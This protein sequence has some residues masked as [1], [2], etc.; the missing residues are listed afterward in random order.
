[1]RHSGFV[2]TV[3]ALGGH[4]HVGWVFDDPD[5]YH[6]VVERFLADGRAAGQQVM[7]VADGDPTAAADPAAQVR[8]YA[9]ATERALADGYTGLRVAADATPL[10]RTAQERAAFAR[11]EFLMDVFMARRPMS[12]L[13]G[14]NRSELGDEA[15]AEL[16][17]MHPVA[18]R[19]STPLRLFAT[20]RP[21]VAAVLA[22]EVDP[23][24]HAQ[25]QNALGRAE[26]PADGGVVTLDAR[27]LTFID[28]RALIRLVEH[29]R[30]RGAGTALLVDPGSPVA[31]LAGLLQLGDLR[32]VMS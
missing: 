5:E 24:G 32:V 3:D 27:E 6:P 22:G 18:R 4:D 23:G 16:A 2:D 25:L 29:V 12:G 11:Y 31:R 19:G 20:D 14:F 10:V 7:F 13:C 9:R 1:M 28:H 17:G 30:G 8:T 21:G 15:V 26:L